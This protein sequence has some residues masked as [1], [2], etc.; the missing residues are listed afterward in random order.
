MGV[1]G[2]P[3]AFDATVQ[4]LTCEVLK[5]CRGHLPALVKDFGVSIAEFQRHLRENPGLYMTALNA[6]V[7]KSAMNK[8]PA[9]LREQTRVQQLVESVV[10]DAEDETIRFLLALDASAVAEDLPEQPAGSLT[11][12]PRLDEPH[13]PQG[14][15][16]IH[17]D[18]PSWGGG[19]R[20]TKKKRK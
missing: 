12:A 9:E 14:L 3:A 11:I 18:K 17:E 20:R 2:G 5:L 19:P 8:L 16:C 1:L 15:V 6:S 4:T 13:R 10:S 7:C